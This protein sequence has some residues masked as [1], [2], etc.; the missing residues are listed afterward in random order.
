M[1]KL[2]KK[3]VIYTLI[4]LTI[5]LTSCKTTKDLF[6][7]K[8]FTENVITEEEEYLSTDIA[9]PEFYLYPDLNKLIKNIIL[10]DWNSFKSY[11]EK[12]WNSINN[13]NSSSYY[14]PFNY[15]VEYKVTYSSDIISIY[16]STYNFSG[17]AHGNTSIKTINYDKKS[18]KNLSITEATDY[19]YD[20]LSDISRKKL[21]EKLISENKKDLDQQTVEIL[22]EMRN[23]GT[24]PFASNFEKFTLN[25]NKLIIY[26]EP[27]TVA[28][29]Y[30][31]VQ[32]I[33]IMKK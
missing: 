32:E 31:G 23:E 20:E 5:I 4:L 33:E 11:S 6:T 27:Y 15:N 24:T 7:A 21:Y 28:P 16:L 3:I 29:Y 12:S 14:P 2:I 22:D 10:A 25:G 18:K 9:Y 19:T 30:Y 26:F 1:I 8:D 17:G 13:L